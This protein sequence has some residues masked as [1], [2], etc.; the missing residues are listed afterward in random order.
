MTNVSKSTTNHQRVLFPLYLSPHRHGIIMSNTII[1]FV[2]RV[3]VQFDLR[4]GR[5]MIVK[6]EDECT[7]VVI[8]NGG[9]NLLLLKL[10]LMITL[11]H[12]I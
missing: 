8:K 12:Q 4:S 11:L 2:H 3:V 1:R 6:T 5:E 7:I 9:E 10:I